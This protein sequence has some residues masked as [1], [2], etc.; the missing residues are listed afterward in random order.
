MLPNYP[1]EALTD[2]SVQVVFHY[3]LLTLMGIPGML[4][5]MDGH[6]FQV[7]SSTVSQIESIA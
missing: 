2:I 6:S 1:E 5:T 4:G 7:V 3:E